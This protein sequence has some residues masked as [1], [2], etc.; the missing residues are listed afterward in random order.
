MM[1]AKHTINVEGTKLLLEDKSYAG[2]FRQ[3][4]AHFI[5][6]NVEK[7]IETINL[8]GIRTSEQPNFIAKNGQKKKNIL[9]AEDFYVY[10]HLTPK[11][12]EKTYEKFELGWDGKWVAEPVETSPEPTADVPTEETTENVLETA[13]DEINQELEMLNADDEPKELTTEQEEVLT[14]AADEITKD[15]LAQEEYG[16]NFADLIPSQKGK[17]TK[18]Y[19]KMFDES[20]ELS[21]EEMELPEM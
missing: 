12:M 5:N 7:T 21:Q 20:Q 19:N 3:F 4:W 15:S 17:I 2:V 9:I 14:A 18:L 1:K 16:V 11:A 6:E 8:V 10:G 13:H